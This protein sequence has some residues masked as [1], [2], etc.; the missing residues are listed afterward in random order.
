ME[1]EEAERQAERE[2]QE[3]ETKM[4]VDAM[5]PNDPQKAENENHP[6]GNKGRIDVDSSGADA[7][8]AWQDVDMDT[9]GDNGA[10]LDTTDGFHVYSEPIVPSAPTVTIPSLTSQKRASRDPAS[11]PRAK[12]GRLCDTWRLLVH[13]LVRDYINYMQSIHKRHISAFIS[14]NVIAAHCRTV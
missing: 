9:G 4:D 10:D 11:T 8:D 3:L 6:T 1:R 5:G 12:H 7:E 13:S 2:G 14:G